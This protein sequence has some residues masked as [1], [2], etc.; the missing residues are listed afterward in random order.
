MKERIK[1][2]RW[3]DR[4]GWVGG[5]PRRLYAF[6]CKH[7]GAVEVKPGNAG[8]AVGPHCDVRPATRAEAERRWQRPLH[9]DWKVAEPPKPCDF[10]RRARS[11]AARE[12][13]CPLDHCACG[14]HDARLEEHE[15]VSQDEP[16][17]LEYQIREAERCA[18][19]SYEP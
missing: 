18:G 13:G 11:L 16:D 12:A 8:T 3:S 14:T 6:T 9:R 4:K 15:C 17:D 5:D 2:P 7:T 10:D 1:A 19:W